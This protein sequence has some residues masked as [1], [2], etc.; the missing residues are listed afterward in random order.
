MKYL[1]FI[2]VSLFIYTN[3]YSAVELDVDANN[4]VDLDKGGTNSPTAAGARTNLGLG[5]V[6]NTS[7]LNKPISTATQAALDAKAAKTEVVRYWES[8]PDAIPGN[9]IAVDT[10]VAYDG[11]LY[12]CTQEFVKTA[13]ATPAAFTSYFS[14]VTGS[15]SYTLP[16]ASAETLGGIKVGDRLTIDGDGVLSADVQ[17][18]DISGKEDS[19]G[20]PSSDGYVLSSSTAG[21]RSWIANGSG[22]SMTWPS[23]AGV[24]V[25][26]GSS[27]W[28]TSLTV[29]TS[30]NNL[31]QLNGSGQLPAVSAA[32]LTNFP[33]LN[34]NTTGTAGGLSGTPSIN[35]SDITADSVTFNRTISPSTIELYEGTA[36]GD[37][38]VVIAPSTSL[39]ENKNIVAE[40]L[41]QTTDAGSVFNAYGT[42]IYGASPTVDSAG[43]IAIDTTSDQLVYY[44]G[45][46]RVLPYTFSEPFVIKSPVDADDFLI[47]PFPHAITLKNIKLIAQGGGSIVITPQICASDA[48]TCSSLE[49]I[50]ADGGVDSDDGTLSYSAVES[51]GFI[52]VLSAAPT[53]TVDFL[54]GSVFFTITAD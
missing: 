16:T 8:W 39:S 36:G 48:T 46:K 11:K 51:G 33:T 42:I 24:A 12:T 43:K 1:T 22:G 28:G 15:G 44:G 34:Q 19:L 2:L 13:G 50:T 31:V 14:E 40:N 25:Y 47:G 41:L 4:A 29:G 6:N 9:T 10:I 27:A 38:K 3:V 35:V 54:S 26:G 45:D 49:A 5:N 20:N 18:T 52:K 23:S 53:G 7:D 37:N 21:V 32:L 30:A 17:T